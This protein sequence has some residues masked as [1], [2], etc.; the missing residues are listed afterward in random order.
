MRP[1]RE[2]LFSQHSYGFRPGRNA[3]DAVP[4][5]Q[6]Y[7]QEAKDWVVDLDITTFFDHVDWDILMGKIGKMIRDKR[8]LVWEGDG[9]QSLSFDP[10]KTD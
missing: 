9:T 8:V 1:I 3:H 5:A 2:P 7:T 10:I 4:A 6:G